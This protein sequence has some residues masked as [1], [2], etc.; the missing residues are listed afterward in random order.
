MKNALLAGC[1]LFLSSLTF[2]QTNV[3]AN[4]FWIDGKPL[5]IAYANASGPTGAVPNAMMM[6]V[7]ADI[8]GKLDGLKVPGLEVAI[9][10][11]ARTTTCDER[12][13]NQVLVCWGS[14]PDNTAT[15]TGY[16]GIDGAAGWRAANV[17]LDRQTAWTRDSLYAMIMHELMHV[18]G[19]THP[20]GPGAAPSVLTGA[21]DLT[22]FDITGLQTMY[23]ARCVFPY[24][25]TT[26]DVIL[27][28]VTY[29]GNAY[30]VTVHYNGDN[31]FSFAN[32]SA[33]S[34]SNLPTTPCQG[35]AVD[36]NNELHIPAISVGGT[37]IWADLGVRNGALVALNSGRN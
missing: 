16:N 7:L 35:L 26:S 4:Y 10:T 23:G 25:T 24:N 18:L 28:Y 12:Q 13:R 33:W 22:S 19:F 36:A 20:D 17:I 27:P 14:V 1:S 21:A 11:T 3:N 9:D 32:V 37:S 31:T 34:P 15:F 8:E 6:Q 30:N 2:G 29:L 5:T